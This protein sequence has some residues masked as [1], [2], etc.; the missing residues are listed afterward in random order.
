MNHHVERV[1][2]VTLAACFQY[3]ILAPRKETT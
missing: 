2:A 1:D 3:T